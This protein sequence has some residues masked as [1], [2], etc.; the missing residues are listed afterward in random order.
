[1][2]NARN[3]PTE[4]RSTS[5]SL[6]FRDLDK[7]YPVIKRGDGIYLYDEKGNR[8]IDGS[9][10]SA[11]VTN[12]GHGVSEVIGTI[13]A[14]AQRIA[15]C[16][17][18]YFANRPAME[19]ADLLATVTPKGLNRVWLV[20]DGSEATENAVKLARQYQIERGKASKYLVVSRWQAYHGGTLGALGYGGH[21]FRRRKYMPLFHDSPHIPPAYCYRCYFEKEYPTCGILCALALEK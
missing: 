10:G 17:S 6:I 18:H 20:T 1:M 19:L 5:S 12:I 2:A 16:P 9:A 13:Q 4:S 11:A 21:T 15:Y 3:G 14:E 7:E 8:Y